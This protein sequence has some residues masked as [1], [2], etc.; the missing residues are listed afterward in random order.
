[1]VAFRMSRPM[2]DE[3][4]EHLR[5]IEQVGFFLADFDPATR[6]FALREWRAV[7]PEGFESQSTFHVT[8]TDAIKTEVIRWAWESGVCLV[9][10]HSH[11]HLGRAE[12]SPSDLWGFRDWVP[13]LFWR[14][15]S[16][17]YAA[18]IT[19]DDAF[20]GLAWINAADAPEQVERIEL[21]DGVVLT[22]T[23]RTL[24]SPGNDEAAEVGT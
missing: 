3:V 7:P 21:G 11:S 6:T 9:E 12:F 17:P 23:K 22:A 1:M 4:R 19:A 13:H 20:D 2:Y 15:R 18:F 24:W 5:D 16:R 8:L 14:L 10:A